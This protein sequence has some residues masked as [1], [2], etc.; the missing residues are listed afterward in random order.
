MN[1]AASKA[2]PQDLG[3]KSLGSNN[4]CLVNYVEGKSG[5]PGEAAHGEVARDISITR[6]CR[7]CGELFSTAD[8][9]RTLCSQRCAIRSLKRGSATRQRLHREQYPEKE[10]CRQ[11][12]KNAVVSGK[13]RRPARCEECGEAG[14]VQAHHEDY[15]KPFFVAWVCLPCHRRLDAARR[16]RLAEQHAR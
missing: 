7:Y 11:T 14:R 15:S 8:R 1:T 13:V 10:L 4:E 3:Q 2:D 12:L 6:Q 9:R 16:R 5:L